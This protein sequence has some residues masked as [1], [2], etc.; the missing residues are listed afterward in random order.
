M[1]R[2][3]FEGAAT[4]AHSTDWRPACVYVCMYGCMCVCY[5]EDVKAP[6]QRHTPPTEGLRVCMCTH[7]HIYCR[8][9]ILI[10]ST[11]IYTRTACIYIHTHRYHI[12]LHIDMPCMHVYYIYIYTHTYTCIY[13]HDEIPHIYRSPL[14]PNTLL[15]AFLDGIEVVLALHSFRPHRHHHARHLH[16][17]L[18]W[19]VCMYVYTYACMYVFVYMYM[20]GIELVYHTY[21]PHTQ[22]IYTHTHAIHTWSANTHL[23]YICQSSGITVG[24]Q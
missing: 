22:S 16:T 9:Q 18:S 2:R 17:P 7:T 1:L 3:G 6:P 20:Y 21:T 10:E 19:W 12:H 13:L 5:V 4:E 15:I 24:S 8:L 11:H 14:P 23:K